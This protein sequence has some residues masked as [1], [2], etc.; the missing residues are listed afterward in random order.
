MYT[1]TTT[2]TC[3]WC[4]NGFSVRV[5]AKYKD[6]EAIERDNDGN[7]GL[8]GDNKRCPNSACNHE[9]FIHYI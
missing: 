9:I 1:N 4:R 6:A 5:G 8:I 3:P 2:V 7:L